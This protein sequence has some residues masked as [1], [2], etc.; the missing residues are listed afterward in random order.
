MLRVHTF[1]GVLGLR[2]SQCGELRS[3]PVHAMKNNQPPMEIG[4]VVGMKFIAA[5]GM[6]DAAPAPTQGRMIYDP[7]K[8]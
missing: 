4:E 6:L 3:S 1:T 2:C 8:E 7:A 5:G